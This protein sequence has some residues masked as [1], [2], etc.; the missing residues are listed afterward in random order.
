MVELGTIV[1]GKYL[2]DRVIGHGGMGLVVQATHLR[3]RQPVA[4]KI[5]LPHAAQDAGTV[6]RFLREARAAVQLRGEHI[7]RV[8][9]VGALDTGTPYMVLEYLEGIDLDRFPRDQLT[10]ESLV[11]LTLQAC[12][13]LAEA[14]ALGIVHRDIKPSN[15][16]IT[17]DLGGTP[18]LK[19]L[20]FGISKTPGATG[21]L[22]ES[23]VMLGTP[24]YMSPEQVRASRKVDPRSDIWSLGVVLYE[25][26]E[27][28]LPFESDAF[29]AMILRIVNDRPAKLTA[30]LPAGL[31]R[32]VLRCLE[33]KPER[34]F[35]ST[36]ELAIALAAYA[37]SPAQ[38]AIT[39][40][41]T[42]A[43]A[44][45]PGRVGVDEPPSVSPPTARW[46]VRTPRWHGALIAAIAIAAGVGAG[47]I[48]VGE[49]SPAAP[50]PGAPPPVPAPS[51]L[52]ESTPAASPGAPPPVLAP[53]PL[54]ERTPAASPAAPA[55]PVLDPV[56][57]PDP[58]IL[59]S[60][61]AAAPGDR[62]APPPVVRGRPL[63]APARRP[64]RASPA[65]GRRGPARTEEPHDSP[66]QATV[67][68]RFDPGD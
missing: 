55:A 21:K 36:A 6:Q 27:G 15:F 29:S 59:P 9:D 54:V 51:P 30:R 3:L 19:L 65:P 66:S 67:P 58:A 16:F 22:T 42:R 5:L 49:D 60:A 56:G 4:L 52:V 43:L 25:L 63:E 40:E 35:Q 38:A 14:H 33:K 45:G 18:F 26:I 31:D 47:F 1:A 13:A 10:I 8:L 24:P 46:R 41:R 34:R 28:R 7:A 17:R 12:E 50:S 11:D 20:D 57:D 62:R 39:V 53:S 68:R 44:P 2:L 48:T 37:G 23:R 64:H 32:I 61:P